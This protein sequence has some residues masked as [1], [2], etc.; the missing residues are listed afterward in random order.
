MTQSRL[1]MT[2]DH[3]V[4]PS[5]RTDTGQEGTQY[6]S[7]TMPNDSPPSPPTSR[8]PQI[9]ETVDHNDV[10]THVIQQR[11]IC[12]QHQV[13]ATH[14]SRRL[15]SQS[16]EEHYKQYIASLMREHADNIKE[17][18]YSIYIAEDEIAEL[19]T[20]LE[21]L[22]SNTDKYRDQVNY[23]M[24][25]NE[26][27]YDTLQVTNRQLTLQVNDLKSKYDET[28]EIFN[29]DMAYVEKEHD[30]LQVTNQQLT[31]HVNDLQSKYD[32]T[33]EKFKDDMA[34][35]EEEYDAFQDI[36]RQLTLQLTTLQSKI[37]MVDDIDGHGRDH[38]P[39]DNTSTNNSALDYK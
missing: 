12:P 36:N 23:N 29:E 39:Y 20:K 6:P 11:D 19:E 25:E 35:V 8:T 28:T 9:R 38:L 13:T 26:I 21:V 3:P 10:Y 34:Y 4:P 17:Y 30:I 14:K 5:I 32:E 24:A 2:N 27:Q 15:Q 37:T 16:V 22:G 7:H 18:E 31:L 1:T 33:Q